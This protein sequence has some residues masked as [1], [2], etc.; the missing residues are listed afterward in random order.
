[1][2]VVEKAK[3]SERRIQRAKPSAEA[4]AAAA[5]AA[6]EKVQRAARGAKAAQAAETEAGAKGDAGKRAGSFREL[7]LSAPLLK[8]CAELRFTDPTP[9]QAEVRKKPF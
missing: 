2:D 7:K 1:M 9:I 8:A 5:A 6:A 3:T 4:A